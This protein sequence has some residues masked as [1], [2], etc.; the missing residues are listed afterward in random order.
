MKHRFDQIDNGITVRFIAEAVRARISP[1]ATLVY[2]ETDRGWVGDV[3]Q[4]RYS[5]NRL[6]AAG[7]SPRRSS[8]EAMILAID[9]IAK[10]DFK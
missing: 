7:W 4:F 5:V 10:Q 6:Q 1:Q 2:G 8:A 3:P 9:E